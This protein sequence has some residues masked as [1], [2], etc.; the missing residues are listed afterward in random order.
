MFFFFFYFDDTDELDAP[1]AYREALRRD[2]LTGVE[3]AKRA[4]VTRGAVAK[5]L[6]GR[7]L[8][9]SM[10]KSFCS[11]MSRESASQLRLAHL[12]DE[13]RRAGER[14]SDYTIFQHDRFGPVLQKIISQLQADPSRI[15]DLI[16]LS[17]RWDKAA[18]MATVEPNQ[19]NP[20]TASVGGQKK[21]GTASVRFRK[22]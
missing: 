14:P 2:R 12:R 8:T 13:L 20:G 7:P 6:G 16:E 22:G 4:G 9:S 10:L 1:K 5:F 18:M 15:H 21:R 17:S 3:M 19:E 11:A